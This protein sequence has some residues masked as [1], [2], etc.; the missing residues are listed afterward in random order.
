MINDHS[1]ID[2][3]HGEFDDQRP[4][5][6]S[7]RKRDMLALQKLGQTLTELKPAQLAK[8]PLNDDLLHAVTEMQRIRQREGRRRQLQ[9]I[10]RLMRSA[11][12]EA[13][14]HALDALNKEGLQQVQ[15]HHLI[16]QWRDRL[17]SDDKNALAE[18]VDAYQ[19]DD[20]QPLAQLIRQARREQDQN[21]PPAAARKL[22][23][24]VR[25]TVT[26]R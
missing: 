18:F 19:P 23:R 7:Q 21:K 24:L 12:H 3:Q 20:V 1:G 9:Y 6:K 5:S 16:E 2:D 17:L 10:G 11:D 22:F 13:I 8:I 14:E 25:D 15:H 4:P 26:S